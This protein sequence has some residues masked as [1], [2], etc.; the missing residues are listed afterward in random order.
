MKLDWKSHDRETLPSKILVL[1][2]VLIAG[3]LLYIWREPIGSV[4]KT[5]VN[6]V[7]PLIYAVII[8][9]ILWPMLRFFENKVFAKLN[10]KK[11]RRRLVRILSLLCTYIIFLLILTLFFSTVIPQVSDSFR[12]LVDRLRDYFN[13][14]STWID[15]L[16][17][18]YPSLDGI[19]ESEIFESIQTKFNDWLTNIVNKLIDNISTIFDNFSTIFNNVSSVA[20]GMKNVVLGIVFAV[21][22]LLYKESLFAQLKKLT[23]SV[24]K[25]RAYERFT[26]YAKLTDRTFGGFISGK[27]IDS[28]IVGLL[29]FILMKIFHMPYA[30]LIAMII[31]ITNVIPFFGPFIGAIPSA[32]FIFVAEPKM[33]LWFILLIVVLQQLDGN[34]IGP[35]ILGD[36]VGLSPLW[37]IVAITI[38]GGIF[39]VWG[40]FFGV[41]TFAVI[42][43]IVKELTERKLEANAL[44]RET[45]EYYQD[46]TYKEIVKPQ[47]HEIP[48]KNN[49]ESVIGQLIE[50]M[51]KN[52]G[53][54]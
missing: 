54:S 31:G 51:K 15:S 46:I 17:E 10:E 38:M 25:D 14:S 4:V 53:K 18:K 47:R 43:A 49:V 48:F 32:F 5:F 6:A 45:D 40:M 29:C 2:G 7:K 22:F 21:Y 26:H 27:L 1:V 52:G 16:V 28:I 9:Y 44:P 39:G 30:S 12:S 11:L 36:F 35:R 50:K 19:F 24:M 37:I 42:Y 8:A 34:V 20:V 41:P 13:N 3:V 23:K 33:T